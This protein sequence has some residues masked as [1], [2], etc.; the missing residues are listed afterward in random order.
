MK[1]ITILCILMVLPFLAIGQLNDY[2][3]DVDNNTEGWTDGGLDI[4]VASPN[5]SGGF[6]F[7][8]GKG[9]GT[10]FPQIRSEFFAPLLA[11]AANQII[12]VTIVAENATDNDK[13]QF[14]N[15]DEGSISFTAAESIAFTMPI[16]TAGNGM[17]TF[18]FDVPRNTDNTDG[19]IERFSLR[20][21]KNAATG[22]TG[23]LK[24]DSITITLITITSE[25]AY[26]SNPDFETGPLD[27]WTLNGS[28]VSMSS[29]T[30]VAGNGSANAI[31]IAFDGPI[32][33][34][35]NSIDNVV[36]DFG[37]TV[38]PSE[39]TAQ[40]DAMATNAGAQFQVSIRTFDA[41]NNTVETINSGSIGIDAI[42]TWETIEI[43]KAVSQPFN[44]IL[45]RLR[46]RG[47][48]EAGDTV[49]IDNVASEFSYVTLNIEDGVTND[50]AFKIYPNPTKGDVLYV[51]SLNQLASSVS[52]YNIT[53]KLVLQSNEI[54]DSKINIS[55]LN[56]GVYV[57]R[58]KGDSNGDSIKKLV[59]NK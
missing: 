47:D 18:E 34:Q 49:T 12:R 25:S 7:A 13:W 3:F 8:E 35:G 38:N 45:F 23:T 41:A 21:N 32:T 31:Q 14:V 55:N 11:V 51:N 28:D 57:V 52:V 50:K 46:F 58:I 36:F 29:P 37:Q 19:G 16:V 40:L 30:A 22:V 26:V 44:K 2:T 24:I 42:N 4:S 1:K 17:S 9:V 5:P 15:L 43:S 20:A 33:S 59:V 54:I 6:L 56:N 27:D 48:A 10:G 53:G 39:V